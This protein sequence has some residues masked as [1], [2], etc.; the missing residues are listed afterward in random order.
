MTIETK[1]D[2]GVKKGLFMGLISGFAAITCCVSPVVLVLIGVATGAEAITLGDTLYYTYGWAF[3][4][5]GLLIAIVAV[6]LYLRRR[7]ACSLKGA[8][9]H[10]RTLAT[11]VISGGAV[12]AGLFWFTKYLGIWFG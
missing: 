1:A 4:A 6:V 2:R 12:Y 5:F 10:W 11:L 3:R 8:R 9:R 7:Q